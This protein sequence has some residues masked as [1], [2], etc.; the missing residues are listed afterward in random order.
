MHTYT[1]QSL[2]FGRCK[3]FFVCLFSELSN[4]HTAYI[5]SY[6]ILTCLAYLQCGALLFLVTFEVH[7]ETLVVPYVHVNSVP[8]WVGYLW[9]PE[10]SVDIRMYMKLC[11]WCTKLRKTLIC[12]D[13]ERELIFRTTYTLASTFAQM[14]QFSC[15]TLDVMVHIFFLK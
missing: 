4:W 11:Q 14:T 6:W 8:L 9:S 15:L 7:V 1:V 12:K 10:T 3:S 13:P 2:L 5:F